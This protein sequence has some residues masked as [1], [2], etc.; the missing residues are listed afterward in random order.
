MK[1]E[2]R[3]PDQ[4]S[5]KGGGNTRT[6]KQYRTKA[7][8]NAT[9]GSGNTHWY[10]QPVNDAHEDLFQYVRTIKNSQVRRRYELAIFQQLYTNSVQ[11]L[12]A[13]GGL[14]SPL[15]GGPSGSYSR[16]SENVVKSCCDTAT[17]RIAKSKPRAFVLPTKGSARL[18]R[19]CKN[20]TKF[21]DGQMAAAS[22]YAN[23]EDVFRD[24][25][26]YGDGALV[27][28]DRDDE[29]TSEVVKIDELIIDQ[30]VGMYDRPK[31]M[32][33]EHPVPRTELLARYPEA[34]K[35]ID[36]ARMAWRG[37][38]GFMSQQD[39]VLTVETWR[40]ES[41][42]GAGDGR[43]VYAICNKTLVDD[44]WD[45]SYIPIYRFHWTP[46]T[47]GPFGDGI[48][49]DLEGKQWLISNILR[50]IAESIRMFAI[51]RIWVDS[52][53]NISQHTI[54]N[55]ITVN[56]YSAGSP[57]VFST[58]PAAAPDVYA[59]VQWLIDSCFKQEGLSQLSA[60]S[61]KPAGLN[62]G[63]AMRTYQDVETQRFAIVGQ[64][65][66]RWYMAVAEGIIDLSADIYKR[67]GKLSVKV[68]GRGFIETVDWS[69]VSLKRDQYDIQVW[70]TNILPE[71]P[72]GKLQA[73]QE[74]T[75]SGFMPRDV[76]IGQMNMPILN[77][78]VDDETAARD[79]I[80]MCLGSIEDKGK[81]I[82]PD[83]VSNIDLCVTMAQ[84]AYLRAQVNDLEEHKI[85]LLQRFLAASLKVQAD[86]KAQEAA[87][88]APPPQMGPGGPPGAGGPVVG[89]AGAP[90]PAPMA[91]VGSGAVQA[92]AAQ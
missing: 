83:P 31:E 6:V 60:Q 27:L 47:Y 71:T 44:P 15:S 24:A 58:P 11:S 32:H 80:E 66:E 81:F 14:F 1:R 16:L 35:E 92:M 75:S 69:D 34:R 22:V 19:K 13:S 57:P 76:A 12:S 89:Q 26:I 82:E 42:P 73:I 61:E 45:K 91:P 10:E 40:L 78:W 39:M 9:Y 84:S 55:E 25:T 7:S 38:M 5:S 46:P 36:E 64:R 70:P 74:W 48:A 2:T 90:P 3:K 59:F 72:E 87:Q 54:T 65:W 50:D 63:V 86:R 79:N 53:S 85:V 29:V 67:K 21:L 68:P 43:H 17:A 49:K 28:R 33:I 88:N 37:A 56:K 23:G 4:P 51:P 41:I 62:S 52:T 77:D 8:G 30:V 20:L 18:K